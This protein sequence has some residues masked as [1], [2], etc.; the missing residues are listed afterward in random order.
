MHRTTND[1]GP[2]PRLDARLRQVG[3]WLLVGYTVLLVLATFGWTDRVE[4][5][6]AA[7]DA[8]VGEVVPG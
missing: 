6:P 5:P 2:L 3:E 4:R 7:T 8:V 1:E